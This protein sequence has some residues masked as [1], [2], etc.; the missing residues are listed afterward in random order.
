MMGVRAWLK[1]RV[2]DWSMRFVDRFR[3]ETLAGACG[4]VLE[5]GFGTGLNLPHYGSEVRGLWGLDPMNSTGLACTEE[6]IAQAPFPVERVTLR[7]DGQL[8]F[9]AGHFDTVVTTWTLCS[10]P[11]TARALGEMRRVLKPGGRYLFIEHGRSRNEKTM[12]WQDRLNPTWLWLSDGCNLNRPIDEIVT[13]GGFELASL[14]EFLGRG[15]AVVS[16]LYRG[17]AIK[18]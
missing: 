5:V 4:N 7:A 17:A 11:D 2:Q 3:S 10:I 13:R 15:P 8:P 9:D 16:S 1:P 12:R 6:R 18:P 14:N